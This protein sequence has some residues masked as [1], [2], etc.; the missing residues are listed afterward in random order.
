VGL[1]RGPL[2]LVSTTEELLEW[3]NSWSG[4][5][6]RKYGREDL[7][8]WSRDTLYPQ[9][10]PLTS[11]TSGSSSV[12]IVRSRTQGRVRVFLVLVY[13]YTGKTEN[14]KLH[15][16]WHKIRAPHRKYRI[17]SMPQ[18]RAVDEWQFCQKTLLWWWPIE[19]KHVARLNFQTLNSNN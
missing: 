3:K 7:L 12:G 5:E 10:L 13:R 18:T 14:M 9:N 16:K 4:L 6:S 8:S 17:S 2:S 1:E 19:S 15:Y 11:T